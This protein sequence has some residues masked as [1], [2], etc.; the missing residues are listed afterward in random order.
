MSKL[1]LNNR[2]FD[3]SKTEVILI[4]SIFNELDITEYV[5]SI[6][7]SQNQ[8]IEYLYENSDTPTHV[9]YGGNRASGNIVLSD[10]GIQRLNEM[11]RNVGSGS[12]LDLGKIID[13]TMVVT[14]FDMSDN[15]Q[16]NET[17][18]IL[19]GL[20]FLNYSRGVSGA[21]NNRNLNFI[22]AKIYEDTT[23]T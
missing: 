19:Y 10:A 18:D 5:V 20:R 12:F 9:G 14:Y 13:M 7:Y 3:K 1:K 4:S 8:S 2:N 6:N 17:S 23:V 15:L 16:P 11:A 21:I 22:L